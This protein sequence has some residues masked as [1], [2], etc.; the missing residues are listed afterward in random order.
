M[1]EQKKRHRRA[2]LR[3]LRDRLWRRCSPDDLRPAY[4]LVADELQSR[5]IPPQHCRLYTLDALDAQ[6]ATLYGRE[7]AATATAV[8]D[9]AAVLQRWRREEPGC[10]RDGDG[11]WVMEAPFSHGLWAVGGPQ[12][13]AFGADDIDWLADVAEECAIGCQHLDEV[14]RAGFAE[15]R[16]RTLVETPDFVVWLFDG[17]GQLLYVSPQVQEWS[18]YAP[19]AFYAA[20]DLW[21]RVVGRRHRA[22]LRRAWARALD[23]QSVREAAFRWRPQD[24]GWRWGS[25]SVL[26]VYD[27]DEDRL[28]N[29][30]PLVQIVV[31]DV[32]ERRQAEARLRQSL[33]EKEVLLQEVHHRVKNNLQVIISLTRLQTRQI[34][35]PRTLRLMEDNLAR[36]RAM[37]M[38]HENLYKA[39][40]LAHIDFSSYLAEL[41]R[42]LSASYGV[43]DRIGLQTAVE[44][45]HLGLDEAVPCGLMVNELVANALKHAFPEG[46]RGH[47]RVGLKESGG[48]CLLTVE[49]DGIGLPAGLDPEGGATLGLKLV[50][51]LAGQIGGRLVLANDGGARCSIFF[52]SRA[53][54]RR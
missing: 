53:G 30:N 36:V 42:H 24:G 40:D 28:L 29:R 51:T 22:A 47:I 3:R 33:A 21:R 52:P 14:R 4:D 54:G 43:G 16:Y 50:S 38:I 15:A 8:V 1:D 20:A 25:A 37:A 2:F 32:T 6:T 34:D 18:G 23:G 7:Q 46:R 39:A 44:L 35:E 9:A 5:G 27:S 17:E 11:G 49:D 26:P 31:Q 45:A 12:A 41:L 10:Y 13:A 19:E 48:Q